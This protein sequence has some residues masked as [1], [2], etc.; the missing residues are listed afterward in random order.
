MHVWADNLSVVDFVSW[1]YFTKWELMVGRIWWKS[2]CWIHRSIPA[3]IQIEGL[4]ECRNST[5]NDRATDIHFRY[6]L[7]WKGEPVS[8]NGKRYC[9]LI[10]GQGRNAPSVNKFTWTN[11]VEQFPRFSH[12]DLTCCMRVCP[13]ARTARAKGDYYSVHLRS[14]T[15]GGR[16]T[17]ADGVNVIRL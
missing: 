16:S 15:F 10:R 12:S 1:N 7:R 17:F 6:C 9:Q 14:P 8:E 5:R 13:A 4:R 2:K 11:R 3:R